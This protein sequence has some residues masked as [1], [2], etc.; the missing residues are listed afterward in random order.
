MSTIFSRITDIPHFEIRQQNEMVDWYNE[1]YE[2][3]LHTVFPMKAGALDGWT[4]N[5]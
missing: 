5:W 2:I 3:L 4:Q 1:V